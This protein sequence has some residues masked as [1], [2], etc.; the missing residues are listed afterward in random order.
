MKKVE[1][2]IFDMDGVLFDTES[3]YL[4][5]WKNVFKRYGYKMTKEIYSQV[6][7]TGRENVKKVF[8]REFGDDLSIEKMY[9]E[10]DALLKEEIEK[11]VPIKEGVVEILNILKNMN[12]K[13]ALATSS[14][15]ERMNKQ[16]EKAKIREY[17][18]EVICRDEVEKTKPNPEIYIKAADKLDSNPKNCLV[19][20]D[21]LAG[22]MAAYKANMKVLHVEDLKKAD[23]EIKKYCYKSFNNLHEIKENIV[24]NNKLLKGS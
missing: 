19:I 14:D 5:V 21:S 18:D 4:K 12:Y 13:I 20:E 10:K 22:V 15:R 11:H 16:L 2:V 1:S 3:I 9:K 24:L 8:L 17:F 6:I 23:N 7:A